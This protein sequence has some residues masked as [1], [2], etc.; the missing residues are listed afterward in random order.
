MDLP[1]QP[2]QGTARGLHASHLQPDLNW[3]VLRNHRQWLWRLAGLQHGLL[4]CWPRLGLWRQQRVCRRLNLPA[5]RLPGVEW[6]QLLRVNREWL[7][8][9]ARL[10][11][12]LPQGR[13]GVPRRPVQGWAQLWLRGSHLHDGEG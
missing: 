5:T 4:G 11:H 12:D 1:E 6:G 13:L 2:V 9:D 3:P 10:Q 8:R 7:R